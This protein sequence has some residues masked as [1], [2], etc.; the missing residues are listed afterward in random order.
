MRTTLEGQIIRVD[1]PNHFVT[2]KT[3]GYN[4]EFATVINHTKGNT[5]EWS[6]E[7]LKQCFIVT[8]ND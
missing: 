2:V 8:Q 3:V 1:E 5:S 6:W 7:D 4:A